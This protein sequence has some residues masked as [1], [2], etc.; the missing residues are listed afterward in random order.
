MLTVV[1]ARR[2]ISIEIASVANRAVEQMYT[3]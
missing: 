1:S 2:N 3:S